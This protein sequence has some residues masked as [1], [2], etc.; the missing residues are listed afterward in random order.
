MSSLTGREVTAQ[1]RGRTK[2]LLGLTALF[3]RQGKDSSE[4]SH[5]KRVEKLGINC[6]QGKDFSFLVS[7]ATNL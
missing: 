4:K 2:T 5:F 7:E 6:F 3:G 1:A